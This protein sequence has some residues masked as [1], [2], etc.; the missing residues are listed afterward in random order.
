MGYPDVEPEN[1]YW[2]GRSITLADPDGWRVVLDW[3]FAEA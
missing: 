2:D 1:P 3:G